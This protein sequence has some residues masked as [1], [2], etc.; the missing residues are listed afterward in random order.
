[1]A[2]G[3]RLDAATSS[4]LAETRVYGG[5]FA[6]GQDFRNFVLAERIPHLPGARCREHAGLFDSDDESGNAK[7][8][9]L[10]A[11]CPA[12]DACEEWLERLEPYQRPRG[13][14][15]GRVIRNKGHIGKRRVS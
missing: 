2:F 6:P 12:L 7:A 1:M 5:G 8:L 11:E 4:G 15:A 3:G 14:V 10:C 13:V 9:S